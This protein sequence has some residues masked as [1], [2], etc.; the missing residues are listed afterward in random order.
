MLTTL[1]TNSWVETVACLI[2][3][4]AIYTIKATS[5]ASY[6]TVRAS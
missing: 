1:L 4:I 2:Q 3:L 5:H 6:E